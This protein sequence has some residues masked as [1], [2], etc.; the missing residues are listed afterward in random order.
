[1]SR[2]EH[3]DGSAPVSAAPG[4]GRGV[5]GEV[6]FGRAAQGF[7]QATV[8]QCH[9]RIVGIHPVRIEVDDEAVLKAADG[10]KREDLC[11]GGLFQIDDEADG[12]RR[13]LT[14]AYA[15]DK[16]VVCHDFLRQSVQYGIDVRV[17]YV[18]DQPARVVERE[19]LVFERGG[20]FQRQ[21]GVGVRRPY[22]CGGELRGAYRF[23]NGGCDGA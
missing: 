8:E 16:G 14:R 3:D 15:A 7:I 13:V 23:G 22:P 20:A 2:I 4:L 9:H 17:L 6:G 5:L 11:V 18:D 10:R 12:G 1:M 21:A 19:V